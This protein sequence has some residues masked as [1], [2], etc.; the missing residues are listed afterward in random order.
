MTK[1]QLFAPSGDAPVAGWDT[2]GARAGLAG[3][4]AKARTARAPGVSD[5]P[6]VSSPEGA[7]ISPKERGDSAL[8]DIA[9]SLMLLQRLFFSYFY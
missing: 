1:C 6:T 7:N 4:I 9:D 5:T 8:I 3:A 2:P